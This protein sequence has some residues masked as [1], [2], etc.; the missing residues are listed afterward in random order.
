M[1]DLGRAMKVSV[2]SFLNVKL[3]LNTFLPP[4][5]SLASYP[6]IDVRTKQVIVI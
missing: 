5:A 4:L 3:G 1:K 6:K 2:G